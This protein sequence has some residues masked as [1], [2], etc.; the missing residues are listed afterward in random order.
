MCTTVANYAKSTQLRT[1]ARIKKRVV[2]ERRIT[3]FLLPSRQGGR[4]LPSR[5]WE[6]EISLT[7]MKIS[8]YGIKCLARFRH[9]IIYTRRLSWV[10]PVKIV[11][12]KKMEIIV[13]LFWWV[14]KNAD[15]SATPVR[16]PMYYLFGCSGIK[17]ITKC[18]LS[19]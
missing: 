11:T 4:L 2:G 7:G 6:A 13:N 5:T 10:K 9:K 3:F 15:R 18:K 12:G 16:L 14:R 17:I 8:T 19:G 1:C